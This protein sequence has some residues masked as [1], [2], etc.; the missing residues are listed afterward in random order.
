MQLLPF[1]PSSLEFYIIQSFIH[2]TYNA[3]CEET[4]NIHGT[5]LNME[6]EKQT[7]NWVR[8]VRGSRMLEEHRGASNLDRRGRKW[9]PK[10]K[11]VKQTWNMN[12]KLTDLVGW[13]GA[14]H[15]EPKPWW[16]MEGRKHFWR[17]WVTHKTR[18]VPQGNTVTGVLGYQEL[19]KWF[20]W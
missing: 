18:S 9:L 20:Y 12:R 2:S 19:V 4:E 10:S 8:S 1:T 16:S 15:V 6:Q 14:T 17:W 7:D 5:E 11:N 13:E 3:Y